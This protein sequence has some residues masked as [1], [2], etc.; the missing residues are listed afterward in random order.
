MFERL[1]AA[2]VHWRIY[3]GDSFPVAAELPKISPVHLNPLSEPDIR[4]IEEL[5]EDINDD[6]FD[7]GFVH[8]EP[9][10]AATVAR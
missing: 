1:E 9:R 3:A 2:G 5:A 8:I 10:S 4:A 6:D 7:A